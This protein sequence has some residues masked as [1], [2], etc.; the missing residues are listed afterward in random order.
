M[1]AIEQRILEALGDS[2]GASHWESLM[3]LFRADREAFYLLA[4]DG[5]RATAPARLVELAELARRVR[6]AVRGSYQIDASEDG[7]HLVGLRGERAFIP[8]NLAAEVAA[9]LRA[10]DGKGARETP[11]KD[12]Q[13]NAIS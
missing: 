4:C 8:P 13:G 11:G 1:N 7:A 9:F 10:V 3:A 12:Y 5:V 6:E 2:A